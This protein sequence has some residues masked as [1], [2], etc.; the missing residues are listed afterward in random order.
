M[1]AKPP[2]GPS[3]A[4]VLRRMRAACAGLPEVSEKIAWGHP[5]FYAGKK[6]FAALD[7]YHGVRCV[8]FKSTLET[9]RR[10]VRDAR[11]F[12][13]PYSGAQGWVCLAIDG[14]I[15]AKEIA[16]FLVEGY[17]LV[18]LQRMLKALEEEARTRRR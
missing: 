10:L 11:F 7:E 5:T 9:Q 4:E 14:R 2:R 17:R 16:A 1:K 15:T 18:A 6:M 8:C 3:D 12:V 13:A